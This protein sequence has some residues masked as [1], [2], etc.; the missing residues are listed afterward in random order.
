MPGQLTPPKTLCILRLS[1]IGD[2]CHT[3]ALVQNIQ[4]HWP[5]T[6]ITWV[7]GRVEKSLVVDLPDVEFVE[8]DK[9]AGFKG[10][11]DLRKALKGRTFDVLFHM[12]LSFRASVA[13]L[14]IRAKTKI[15]FDKQRSKEGQHLFVNK[16]IASQ[17]Q[18]HVVD[19]FLAFAQALGLPEEKPHWEM[20]LAA[21]DFLIVDSISNAKPIAVICPAASN[22]ERNWLPERYA[23][24]ADK[25]SAQ[26]FQVVICGAPTEH[27]Y[28]LADEII[29][30]SHTELMNLVGK[31]DLK[32]LLATLKRAHFVLSPDTGPA[33]MA[34]SVQTPVIGL[35]AHSNPKRTGPYLYQD[36]V[37]DYY[38]TAIAHQQGKSAEELRWGIRAKGDNLMAN[39]TVEQVLNKVDLLL[40]QYPVE[41]DKLISVNH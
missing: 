35:Y 9:K 2:V 38:Q 23:Q 36:F 18:A 40:E 15:G 12:Q 8:F 10:Y 5:E 7:I 30:K 41:T 4:K 16:T 31:T 1:A 13:S 21:K 26:G 27:E 28:R 6:K 29:S 14:C 11:L 19:S 24:A 34:V 17:H 32:G 25:L 33:H 3:V 22:A 39:I 37:V 20:P